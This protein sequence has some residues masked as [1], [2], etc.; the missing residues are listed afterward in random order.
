MTLGELVKEKQ[1]R[2]PGTVRR[3]WRPTFFLGWAVMVMGLFAVLLPLT[4]AITAS[5]LI[6]GL[7]TVGGISHSVHGIAARRVE[8]TLVRIIGG[9]LAATVGVVILTN[10]I[11]SLTGIAMLV[12]LFLV[13][14]GAI[15]VW[16]GL[17]MRPVPS[18]VSATTGGVLSI[19]LGLLILLLGPTGG[20]QLFGAI[21]GLYLFVSGWN[22]VALAQAAR[23]AEARSAGDE[24]PSLF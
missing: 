23:H 10:P 7:L 19:V 11:E 4:T 16:M 24:A 3:A 8:T 1:K 20:I 15:R 12:A 2:V 9:L 21:V 14:E 18:W 22:L 6:G 17:A 5:M 13:L